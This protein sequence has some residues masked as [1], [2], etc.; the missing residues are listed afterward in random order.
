VRLSRI[1]KV[2]VGALRDVAPNQ[3]Y[4]GGVQVVLDGL[5]QHYGDVEL[6]I[7]LKRVPHEEVVDVEAEEKRERRGSDSQRDD[8]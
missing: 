7:E 4:L 1:A 2:L 8:P 5:I 6:N 3:V